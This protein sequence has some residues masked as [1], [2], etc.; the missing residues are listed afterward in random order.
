MCRSLT[1][2]K[3]GFGERK[4]NPDYVAPPSRMI[5]NISYCCLG[6]IQLAAWECVFMHLYATG[7]LAYIAD[8]D[9]FSSPANIARTIGWTLVMNQQTC[10]CTNCCFQIPLYTNMHI[11]III[12]HFFKIK[13][14]L[15]EQV[16]P[17]WRSVHFYFAHRFIHIHP[18]YKYVHSLH[19]RNVDIEPVRFAHGCYVACCVPCTRK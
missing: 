7:K 1:L 11:T 16:V 12:A 17:L 10:Y 15:N 13:M 14:L 8:A 6:A 2:Y 9:L 18:L 3:L 19:H 5:H 4:F